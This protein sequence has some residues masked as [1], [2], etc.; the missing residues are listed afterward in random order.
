MKSRKAKDTV[1]KA[2][3]LDLLEP[4]HPTLKKNEQIVNLN[5]KNEFNTLE[6]TYTIAEGGVNNN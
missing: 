6:I 5:I 4:F 1:T 3:L 2:F